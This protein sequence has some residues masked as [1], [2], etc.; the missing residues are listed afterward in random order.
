MKK[1]VFD[2]SHASQ[3]SEIPRMANA[4]Q[5]LAHCIKDNYQI[6]KQCPNQSNVLDPLTLL[7][8]ICTGV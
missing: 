6:L 7:E 3:L 4:W 8:N 5:T 1:S 2:F